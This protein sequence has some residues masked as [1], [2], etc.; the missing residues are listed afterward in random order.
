MKS[1]IKCA[2]FTIALATPAQPATAHTELNCATIKVIIRNASGEDRSSRALEY[3]DFSIDDTAKAVV[4]A[5][6]TAANKTL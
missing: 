4:F 2:A 5:D 3:L 6:G 1:V